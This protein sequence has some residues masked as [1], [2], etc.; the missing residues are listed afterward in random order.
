MSRLV[1]YSHDTFGLGNIRRMLAISRHLI[2]ILPDL[3]ILLITGSP[4]I[5]SFRLPERLDYI[6]LP[7]LSRTEREKYSSKFLSIQD[8]E[9]VR[10]RAS[11]IREA[12]ALFEP[13]LILV[14]K[15]P[16][17]VNNELKETLEHLRRERPF[18]THALVL[19]DI[20][21]GPDATIKTWKERDYFTAVD[22]YDRI[23]VLGS[24]WVFDV[25]EEYRF[26]RHVADKVMFCGY[27]QR[28][29]IVRGRAEVRKELG[30]A[31]GEKLVLVTTGGGEDGAF[32]L[33]TY[34]ASEALFGAESGI[35]SLMI[36]G[37][38]I[39]EPQ[40]KEVHKEA[41]LHPR[42][43]LRDFTDDM[44][45]YMNAAD[46]VVSMGGYNTTCEILTLGKRA[47][48]VPRVA[49][50][51]EQ[52][53]RAERLASLG[54]FKTIRADRLQVENLAQAVF[55]EL[56][57]GSGRAPIQLD[58][59]GLPRI[60]EYVQEVLSTRAA[61]QTGARSLLQFAHPAFSARVR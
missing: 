33:K 58:L 37:P 55:S 20:I 8:E 46:L 51:E 18:T 15:K 7:C 19:R 21:D 59:N 40:R 29:G 27:T 6:K 12:T 53:I 50:V 31:E 56:N 26:P 3:N 38:E 5:H 28:E 44:L 57:S 11:L 23:L 4:I 60:A 49:P 25:R 52:V 61:R 43:T 42:V 9:V 1:V 22:L 14:D 10:L 32:L 48:V 16:Y 39:P 45:S 36:D 24:P 47:V 2:E 17:G 54:L 41:A 35:R 13:D 30:I 34:F